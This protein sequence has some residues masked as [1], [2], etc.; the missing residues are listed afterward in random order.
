MNALL[1]IGCHAAGLD[2]KEIRV[3]VIMHTAKGWSIS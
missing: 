2:F 3:R 1:R